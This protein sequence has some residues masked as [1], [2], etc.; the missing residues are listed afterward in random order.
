M[1]FLKVFL[2]VGEQK[3][4]SEGGLGE[5]GGGATF[6]DISRRV[7]KNKS[8]SPSM[9]RLQSPPLHFLLSIFLFLR[10]LYLFAH[11]LNVQIVAGESEDGT[12][13]AMETASKLGARV[14]A[15]CASV[16]S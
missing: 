16:Y 5:R 10:L 13:V 9:T 1:S 14:A 6:A 11:R 8:S 3:G 15:A 12:P 4:S 7:I 2:A